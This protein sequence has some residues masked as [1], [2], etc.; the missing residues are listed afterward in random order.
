LPVTPRLLLA[1][2]C[3]T[4]VGAGAGPQATAADGPTLSRLAGQSIVGA[5]SGRSPSASFVARVRRG[6]LGGVILFGENIGSASR[7]ARTVSALRGAAAAGG[8]PHL[9]ILVDQEGGTV[10]RLRSAPPRASAETMGR[11]S[12]AQ[13]RA[14]GLRTGRVL[15]ARGIDV[16]LAP[17]DD[18]PAS[19]RSFLGTRA[20][21][22]DRRVVASLATAFAA[23]LQTGRV[24]A[25]AKHFPGLGDAPITTDSAEVVVR[26]ER[27]RLLRDL[28]PFQRS[29]DA[30]VRLVMVSSAT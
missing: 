27:A 19:T 22:R 13:V 26:T 18:V 7:L 4:L 9:L 8:N 30:G 21:S 5:F 10:R 2:A 15:R 17:V 23:G 16:D 3:L 6:E 12:P 11:W 20:F 1:S 25:T 24:A 14:E 29:V 28:L